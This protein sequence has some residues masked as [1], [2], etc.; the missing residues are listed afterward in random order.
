MKRSL[1]VLVAAFSLQLSY[2]QLSVLFV[3]DDTGN[4]SN[5]ET[6]AASLDAL[7]VDYTYYDANLN[8]FGPNAAQMAMYDLVIWHTASD[9]SGLYLWSAVD[10]DNEEIKEYLDGGGSLWLVGTD[11]TLDR[12][13]PPPV[14]YEEGDFLY[15]YVGI[16]SFDFETYNDDGYLGLPAAVPD[17]D[18]PITGLPTLTWTFETLWF[19]DAVTPREG[20]KPIMLMGFEDYENADSICGVWH[21]N[22]N[23]RVLTFFFDMALTETEEQRNNTTEA[24]LNFFATAV[25][26]TSLPIRNEINIFPNPSQGRVRVA[27]DLIESTRCTA[28]VFDAQGRQVDV[29]CTDQMLQSGAHQ[30]D[31]NGERYSNGMYWLRLEMDDAVRMEKIVLAR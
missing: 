28:T 23:F 24:V 29:I 11:F 10:E 4:Y 3:D 25:N 17:M 9:Q 22:G 21:N 1:L 20:V 18:Q 14:A 13:G 12:Y 26:T 6:F 30:M 19:V 31:W 7:S 8:G 15:D 27:F 16:E 2:G 5:A